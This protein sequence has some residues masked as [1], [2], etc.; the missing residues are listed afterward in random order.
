MASIESIPFCATGRA[1]VFRRLQDETFD[2]LV[3]GGG[4]TGA[5][6]ARDATL[7]GF[8]V[9]LVD[10]NDFAFGTSSRS[11]K[12][13][14]GGFRYLKT[15]EF[16]LVK[17]SEH[18]R[19]WLRNALPHLVRPL[20]FVIPSFEGG[21][22]PIGL[23]RFAIFLYNLLDGGGNYQKGKVFKNPAAITALEPTVKTEG[24][25]GGGIFWDTNIDDARLTVETIKEAVLTGKCTALNHVPVTRLHVDEASGKVQ[26]AWITDAEGAVAG[27]VLVKA[28]IVVNATGIW[29]DEV[30]REKPD[31][32]PATVIRPT[33]GVHVVFKKE[34]CPLN[35][36]TGIVSLLDGR[37]Y[38]TL[39]REH[40]VVIGTTDTDYTGDLNDPVCDKE[41]AEYLLH[42]VRILFPGVNVGY[43]KMVGSYAGIR[44]L[45]VPRSKKGGEVSESKVSREHEIIVSPSGLLTICGGKLTTFRVMA[46]QLVRGHVI[47]AARTLL[48]GRSFD[49]KKN[50]ARKRYLISMTRDEWEAHPVV[51]A[52]SSG[53]LSRLVDAAQLAHLHRQYGR[54]GTEILSAVRDDPSGADRLVPG[55]ATKHAPWIAAEVRYTIQ[56]DMPVHLVDILARRFEIQWM[57]H[58]SH[59]PAA[60]RKV[61]AIAAS[62]LGWDASRVDR[63]V[64]GYL[65]Y[66]KRNAFFHDGPLE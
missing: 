44:P 5:G 16:G 47:P 36:A 30:L 20:G 43:D 24:L 60:A 13:A 23:L 19:N 7:R 17:E 25:K 57:V 14:H 42:T 54:G 46:E 41:D 15:F 11:S 61:A 49:N 27:E 65:A 40:F 26:G 9:A 51:A 38:F 64:K 39:T 18:E 3:I 8:T 63:E 66:L 37:F 31:G 2:I 48:P 4:V 55:E 62:M 1:D 22:Y 34:D 12:L 33:K 28:R 32:Y 56:H 21:K 29:T 59:Q 52:F 53:D 58:P 10:K 50:I 45:V 35:N 6:I